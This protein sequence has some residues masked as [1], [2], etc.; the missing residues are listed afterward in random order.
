MRNPHQILTLLCKRRVDAANDRC[1]GDVPLADRRGIY[2][3]SS[4]GLG[5]GLLLLLLLDLLWVA[6]EEHIHHNV[7]AI[8]GAGDGSAEAEHFTSEEPPDEADRMPRLVICRDRYVDVPQGC[9][10]VRKRNDGNVD[11]GCLADGLVV[12]S[13]IGHDDQP[14]LLER[15]RDIIC[16]RAWGES[17]CDRLRAG[18]GS[19]LEDGAMAVW[20]CGDHANVIRV[21]DGGNNPGSKDELL[22]CLSNVD[23]MDT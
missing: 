3:A 2:F 17:A 14:R 8:R 15:A 1:R 21:F 18:V 6:V 22:P 16:E 19:I 23:D 13:W 7:P 10:R 5:L 12:D 11:V 4:S 20:S 9:I